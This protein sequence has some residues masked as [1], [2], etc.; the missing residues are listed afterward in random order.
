MVFYQASLLGG[1]AWAHLG[2]RQAGFRWQWPF[3]SFSWRTLFWSCRSRFGEPEAPVSERLAPAL[4]LFM[5][6]VAAA[7]LPLFVLATM[8]PTLATMVL[9]ER[10]RD[11]Q[12]PYFL[13]ATSNAGSLPGC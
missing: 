11:V 2:L 9:V 4:W 12:D 3:T 7:G 8:T 10:H 5:V 13:Y 6:L 1:Y